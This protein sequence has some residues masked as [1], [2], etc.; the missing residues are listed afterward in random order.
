ML[1]STESKKEKK[2]NPCTSAANGRSA[3]W[4]VVRGLGALQLVGRGTE[5]PQF[6]NGTCNFCIAKSICIKAEQLF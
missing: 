2:K 4:G 3:Q 5:L 1:R 6:R